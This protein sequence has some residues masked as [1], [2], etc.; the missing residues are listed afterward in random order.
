MGWRGLG[1]YIGLNA[2]RLALPLFTF[3]GS[4]GSGEGLGAIRTLL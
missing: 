3:L 2:K 1:G 4:Q